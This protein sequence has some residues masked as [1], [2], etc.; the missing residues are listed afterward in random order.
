[1]D[2]ADRHIASDGLGWVPSAGAAVAFAH[3]RDYGL[4]L[5]NRASVCEPDVD[6]LARLLDGTLVATAAYRFVEFSGRVPDGLIDQLATLYGQM[7]DAPV[8]GLDMQEE[9]WSAERIRIMEAHDV[10]NGRTAHI[11]AALTAES[12]MVAFTLLYTGEDKP[13][14][15][16]QEET[17]VSAAHRGHRLGLAVKTRS[18]IRVAS[19]HPQLRRI[20]TW[21]AAQNE[22]MLAI[23]TAVGFRPAGASGNWQLP[24]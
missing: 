4:D 23:N 24:L 20:Y 11:T 16:D 21:N 17:L 12:E 5:V 8:G 13:E 6:E 18:M 2:D 19:G 3:G 14:K 9:L 22:H 7:A 10:A 15:G 1:M